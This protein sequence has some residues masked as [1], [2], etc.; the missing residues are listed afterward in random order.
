[1]NKETAETLP[2]MVA[3]GVY[4][5]WV[6]CGRPNCRCASGRPHGPY[7]YRF[8]RED[9]RLRKRYVKQADVESVRACCQLRRLHRQ[10]LSA[11]QH[12]W[13]QMADAVR[14]VEQRN[15]AEQ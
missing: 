9:G 11:Y 7:T 12:K 10:Q 4:V 8:W 1:M 5:Q 14:R 13:R 6:R 15:D 3:G 2:K